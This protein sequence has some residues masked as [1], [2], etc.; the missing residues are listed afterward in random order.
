MSHTET[1]AVRL[2]VL[3]GM[4]GEVI[5]WLRAVV[6]KPT[7]ALEGLSGEG[8]LFESF[9]LERNPDGDFVLYVTRAKNMAEADRLYETSK[10]LF[11]VQARHFWASHVEGADTLEL[12]A[13]LSTERDSRLTAGRD[14]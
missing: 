2:R 8:V 11:D 1:R 5:R 6:T 4:T 3:P 7:K 14:E 13:D 12:I 10:R 9:F